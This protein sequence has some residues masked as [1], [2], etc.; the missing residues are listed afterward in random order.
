MKESA[1]IEST[2]KAGDLQRTIKINAKNDGRITIS[3]VD[4][5]QTYVTVMSTVG[6]ATVELDAT[7]LWN[8]AEGI[9]SLFGGVALCEDANRDRV[10]M[11]RAKIVDVLSDHE[12]RCL[13]DD[14]D[15]GVVVRELLKALG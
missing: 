6:H 11:L 8:L 12:A 7:Q 4:V 3:E 1:L 10:A 14:I 15:R 5:D 2:F 9:V 13:D